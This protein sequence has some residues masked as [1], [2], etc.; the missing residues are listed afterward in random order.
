MSLSETPAESPL[1]SQLLQIYAE[2]ERDIAAAAPVCDLSGR[3]CRFQEYGHRLYLS[4][5]EAELLLETGLPAG[6]VMDEA[7]CP[8]QQGKLCTA[9][10]R[11][12]LGCRVYFC[13]P[14]YTGR[15]EEF[16]EHYIAKLKRLHQ[17]ADQ[18]WEY[19]SL[20]EFLREWQQTHAAP[21]CDATGTKTSSA[22]LEV[23]SGRSGFA[24]VAG[25][26]VPILEPEGLNSQAVEEP[27]CEQGPEKF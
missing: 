7:G 26:T 20:H 17:A 16:S 15:A 13:D 27:Y 24:E 6:A 10:E 3:C 2:V 4:R 5:P 8:F 19:G 23:F 11:R 12:P 25:S 22:D 14:G 9:R 21:V 1:R 18:P